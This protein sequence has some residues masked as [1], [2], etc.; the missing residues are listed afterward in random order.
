MRALLEKENRPSLG[1]APGQRFSAKL[2]LGKSQWLRPRLR[3]W[4]SRAACSLS[5]LEA[6][7]PSWPSPATERRGT[8]RL[9]LHPQPGQEEGGG[10]RTG[11]V[12]PPLGW[13]LQLA[14]VGPFPY[15]GGFLGAGL[16]LFFS[17]SPRILR[18][19][20][21]QCIPGIWGKTPAY[22]EKYPPRTGQRTRAKTKPRGNLDVLLLS[23]ISEHIFL[24]C[25]GVPLLA[26][27]AGPWGWLAPGSAKDLGLD[28]INPSPHRLGRQ[29]RAKA[30]CPSPTRQ[31]PPGAARP[32]P[33]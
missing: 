5:L 18:G 6:L 15:T 32:R 30:A 25:E 12:S 10:L 26:P 28:K 31:D 13:R 9:C 11:A 21:S 19:D 22:L 2:L 7:S 24:A 14:R 17:V 23:I 4:P 3:L 29:S 8:Q 16:S 27:S 1:H 33:S 20:P